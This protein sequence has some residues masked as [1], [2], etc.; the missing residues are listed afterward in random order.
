M[1]KRSPFKKAKDAAWDAFSLYIRTRDSIKTTGG[2]EGCLC[3]SCGDWRPRLGLYCIQAG[4]FI[5]GRTNAVLFSEEGVHGQ[6]QMCNHGVKG[7]VKPTS[8]IRYYQFMEK[9]YGKE[10]IDR[11]VLES[12]QIVKYKIWD[13]QEIEQKYKK[14][15]QELL[16]VS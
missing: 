16:D 13:Y 1:A 2:L 3:V 4:H 11:L 12:N 10:V 7:R 14:K 5:S 6:C 8:H 15:L 9:E